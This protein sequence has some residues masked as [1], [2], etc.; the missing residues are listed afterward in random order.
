V[1]TSE[2][3][4]ELERFDAATAEG[5][6][7]RAEE[8]GAAVGRISVMR[9]EA[10]H[11]AWH[12]AEAARVGA[13]IWVSGQRG[14]DAQDN[15]SDDPAV[16]ARV[17]FQ[18]LERTLVDAGAGIDDV[19]SLT[20]YHLDMADVDGFRAVKDEFIRQPYPAWTV[21][22]VTALAAPEM[23]VEIAAVAVAGSGRAARLRRAP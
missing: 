3:L 22:G 15:I 21:V 2:G 20:T 18:N 5:D 12:F 23:R 7:D 11:D 13:M 14:F 8:V 1:G 4:V 10:T 17:A 9:S 16:Q 19:V 6:G